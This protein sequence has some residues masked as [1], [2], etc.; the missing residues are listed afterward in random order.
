[1]LEQ[2]RIS[3]ML[4]LSCVSHGPSDSCGC[5]QTIHKAAIVSA[6]QLILGIEA[7]WYVE[8]PRGNGKLFPY[9]ASSNSILTSRS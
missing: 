8:S 4:I 1:M 7:S 2:L 3:F 9:L 5:L 6:E